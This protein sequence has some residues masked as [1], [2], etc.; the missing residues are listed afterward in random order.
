MDTEIDTEI[1]R[2]DYAEILARKAVEGFQQATQKCDGDWVG[3]T[4]DAADLVAMTDF[5]N[6]PAYEGIIDAVCIIID[7]W[8]GPWVRTLSAEDHL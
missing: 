2:M 6:D 5:F 8:G 3:E 1:L 7:D 4:F